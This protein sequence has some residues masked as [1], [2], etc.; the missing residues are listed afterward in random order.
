M[1]NRS[2]WKILLAVLLSFLAL[3][4]AETNFDELH[5]INGFY[6]LKGS[7]APF[8]GAV[9]IM[10]GNV[11]RGQGRIEDGL[12]QGIWRFYHPDGSLY[13]KG[14][15]LDGDG[16]SESYVSG[17]PRNGR[18]GI[19][20]FYHPNGNKS[21]EYT[22]KGRQQRGLQ[23]EWYENGQIR[24][25]E[26]LDTGE[27][28][29]WF[30]NGQKRY[31][32]NEN[33]AS[34]KEWYQNGKIKKELD[35]KDGLTRE[36]YSNGQ[37][38]SEGQMIGDIR[39]GTWYFWEKDGT[40]TEKIVYDQGVRVGQLTPAISES[41]SESDE[42]FEVIRYH[43]N[44][45]VREQGHQKPSGSR[46]G[47]WTRFYNNGNKESE[48]AFE[49]G[50]MVGEWKF[51]HENG[52]LSLHQ[53]YWAG[54]PHGT[55]RR[56]DESGELIEKGLYSQGKKEGQWTIYLPNGEYQS[57][58]YRNDKKNGPWTYFY[59]DGLELSVYFSDGIA[60][61][62]WTERINL[63]NDSFDDSGFY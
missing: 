48:G 42:I 22:Y 23:S 45:R 37:K 62:E 25:R 18:E 46:Q 44:K 43:N 36:W 6:C 27:L 56:W 3:K 50:T 63:K 51:W 10:N 35:V 21:T 59:K 8:T 15:F 9:V 33:S 14:L 24:R 60:T 16:L 28:E 11:V 61:G 7:D 57:G 38:K 47:L 1:I 54:N 49:N 5:Y 40:L 19:W 53:F 13:A 39:N 29:L 41:A 12:Y 31:E 26:N 4:G 32:G 2:F 34:F 58:Y 20:T 17:I 30:F 52:K 55:H